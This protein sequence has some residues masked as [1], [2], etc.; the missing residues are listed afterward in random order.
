[1]TWKNSHVSHPWPVNISLH[2]NY[3]CQVLLCKVGQCWPVSLS[4]SGTRRLL[5]CLGACS[6]QVL[7]SRL[8]A[9]SEKLFWKP[10]Q[11]I[12]VGSPEAG[13]FIIQK[14]FP[15]SDNLG[16]SQAFSQDRNKSWQYCI[17]GP[18]AEW[19]CVYSRWPDPFRIHDLTM[20]KISHT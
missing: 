2:Q 11:L 7:Q 8:V 15:S 20:L 9:S 19:W 4:Y 12:T 14:M 13:N 6:S 1:M 16:R 17:S 3:V 5:N 10:C 18:N